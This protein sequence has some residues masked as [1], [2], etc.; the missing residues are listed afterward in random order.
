MVGPPLNKLPKIA[1]EFGVGTG[2]IQEIKAE[3]KAPE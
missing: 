2:T 1:A 3:L